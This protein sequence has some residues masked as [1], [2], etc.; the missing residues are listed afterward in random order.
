MKL[1]LDMSC[2]PLSLYTK[3]QIDISRYVE[4]SLELGQTDGRTLPRHNTSVFKT[5]VQNAKENVFYNVPS[6]FPYKYLFLLQ[7]IFVM[8]LQDFRILELE[9]TLS[10]P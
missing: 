10:F 5:D 7:L 2:Y 4:K 6:G 8:S 1:K 3:F 9:V